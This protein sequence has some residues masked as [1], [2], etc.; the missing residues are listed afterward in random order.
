LAE[1]RKKN[2]A[3]KRVEKK[4]EEK[5]STKKTEKNE[6]VEKKEMSKVFATTTWTT[7][8][9]MVY[10][11]S[12]QEG[13]VNEGHK[14]YERKKIYCVR[15]RV[16][17]ATRTGNTRNAPMNMYLTRRGSE[18]FFRAGL[19]RRT[20][21][22]WLSLELLSGSGLSG[23]LYFPR[24]FKLV[25]ARLLGV[26]PGVTGHVC[27][28]AGAAVCSAAARRTAALDCRGSSSLGSATDGLGESDFTF[29][30]H[31][32]WNIVC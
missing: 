13:V 24:P 11:P 28:E 26:A 20:R 25:L 8:E 27:L 12:P 6:R 9:S 21:R 16:S 30:Q 5:Q 32:C 2:K 1:G 7:H 4:D 3:P 15:S 10:R 18:K 22:L 29:V 23:G 14:K 31:I 17:A 19:A